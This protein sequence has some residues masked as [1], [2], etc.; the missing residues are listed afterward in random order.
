MGKKLVITLDEPA[1]SK[2][3]ELVA[4]QTEAELN[5]DCEP[6]GA[7]LII[8]IEPSIVYDSSVSFGDHEIGIVS[9]DLVNE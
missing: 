2:Y 5:E 1:T 3:L 4:K 7:T 8:D 9:I 6:S